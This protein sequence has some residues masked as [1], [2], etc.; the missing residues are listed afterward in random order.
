VNRGPF[1]FLGILVSLALSFWGLVF[2]PQTQIGQQQQAT[3]SITGELY[4]A[5]RSGLAR[6]GADVYRAE[7]CVECHSQ[8]V[9]NRSFGTDIERGWGVRFTV[10]QDYLGD[11]PVML[12]IQR[13]GPDLANISTRQPNRQWHLQHLYDPKSLVAGSIMPQYRYLFEKR[14]LG[15]RQQQ[16]ERALRNV[17]APAGYEIVPTDSAEALVA[18]LLSLRADADLFEGPVPRPPGAETNAVPGQ[19]GTNA[20]NAA[21]AP[22]PAGAASTPAAATPPK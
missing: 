8:Q 3:N 4:P 2:I 5:S 20:T 6:R 7:G 15:L 13:A 1:I 10:A 17:S 22:V 11:Y 19:A 21:A 9:R 12:G 14:R 18:Y 16:S